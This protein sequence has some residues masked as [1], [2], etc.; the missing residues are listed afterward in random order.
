MM[1]EVSIGFFGSTT[2]IPIDPEISYTANTG[3]DGK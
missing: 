2:A 3:L 1:G